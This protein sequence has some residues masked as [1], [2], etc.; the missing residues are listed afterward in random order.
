MSTRRTRPAL[1]AAL[2]LSSTFVAVSGVSALER[3]DAAHARRERMFEELAARVPTDSLARLYSIA[4]DAPAAEGRVLLDA[5][6][7]QSLRLEWAYGN[8]AARKAV[9]RMSDSLFATPELRA[10]WQEARDRWPATSGIHFDCVR[11][12]TPAADSL[13]E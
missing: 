5:V 13:S 10:R 1:I 12:L 4:L 11:G 9:Q 7:C 6:S 3:R 8:V 2:L